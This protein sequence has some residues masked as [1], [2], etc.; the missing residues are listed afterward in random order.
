MWLMPVGMITS[1][2]DGNRGIGAYLLLKIAGV[3]AINSAAHRHGCAEHL[4]NGTLELLGHA[5]GAHDARTC[6][7]VVHGNVARVLDVLHL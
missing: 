6:D 3:R 2:L 5:T 7:D 1:Y 4:L